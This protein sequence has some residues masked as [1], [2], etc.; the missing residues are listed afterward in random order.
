VIAVGIGALWPVVLVILGANLLFR[1][2]RRRDR[3][4]EHDS[5]LGSTLML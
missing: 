2:V 3:E 5:D 1:G 4:S